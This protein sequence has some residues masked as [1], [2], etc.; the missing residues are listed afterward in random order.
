MPLDLF[1]FEQIHGLAGIFWFDFTFHLLGFLFP[2]FL[3]LILLILTI[4]DKRAYGS[5]AIKATAMGIFANFALAWPIEIL[6]GRS[7]PFAI[8]GFEPLIFKEIS[9]LSF[10]SS[11]AIFFFTLATILYFHHKKLG[12]FFYV[13]SFLI[14]FARIY[15]GIHWPTDVIVGALLGLIVGLIYRKI[16][17]NHTN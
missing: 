6:I 10:P 4:W 11:H 1:L 8:L 3:I 16:E 13:A 5:I 15:A 7:R 14:V 9:S 12:I 2:Y 17:E